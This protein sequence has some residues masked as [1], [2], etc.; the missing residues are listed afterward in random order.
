M[1]QA[2]SEALAGSGAAA[3]RLGASD[4]AVEALAWAGAEGSAAEV[5]SDVDMVRGAQGGLASAK[6]AK[7]QIAQTTAHGVSHSPIFAAT[8]SAMDLKADPAPSEDV[9]S[10][11]TIGR[12]ASPCLDVPGSRGMRPRTSKSSSDAAASKAC[13]EPNSSCGVEQDEQ[14]KCDWLSTPPSIRRRQSSV[15]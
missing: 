2:Q 7:G 8:R 12:P 10:D 1:E 9:A 6:R 14:T 13:E 3:S 15:C 4:E 11:R 5:L